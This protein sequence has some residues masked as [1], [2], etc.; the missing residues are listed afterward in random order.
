M[1]LPIRPVSDRVSYFS[2]DIA[3]AGLENPA[4]AISR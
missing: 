2:Q 3:A 4:A 1:N